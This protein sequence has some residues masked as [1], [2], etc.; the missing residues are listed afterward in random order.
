MTKT[1]YARNLQE[2]IYQSSLIAGFDNPEIDAAQTRAWTRMSILNK[3][4]GYRFTGFTSDLLRKVHKAV[5]TPQNELT[6]FERGFFRSRTKTDIEP[7]RV[8]GVELMPYKEVPEAIEWWIKELPNMMPWQA[9]VAFENIHPFT[10]GNGRVGRLIY[11]F[12][13][14]R[15]NEHISVIPFSEKEKYNAAFKQ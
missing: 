4:G 9:H 12:L 6:H 10:D 14:T 2:A 15:N 8:G 7:D 13:Q 5:V 1:N 3:E 11:W